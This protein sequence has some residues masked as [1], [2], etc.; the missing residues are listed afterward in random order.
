MLIISSHVTDLPS[1]AS[2]LAEWPGPHLAVLHPGHRL[3]EAELDALEAT[4]VLYDLADHEPCQLSM[5]RT[6]LLHAAARGWVPEGPFLFAAG[7]LSAEAIAD[8]ATEAEENPGMMRFDG[9]AD[10][11]ALAEGETDVSLLLLGQEAAETPLI[12][13][14]FR[15][16]EP[17][18]SAVHTRASL[19]LLQEHLG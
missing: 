10:E 19:D 8:L 2:A 4:F 11:A 9:A 5:L 18:L 7:D 15:N 3:T 13:T 6:I 17:D 12:M 1:R 14:F 16:M